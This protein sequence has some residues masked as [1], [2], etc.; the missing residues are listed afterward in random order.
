MATG[1]CYVPFACVCIDDDSHALHANSRSHIDCNRKLRRVPLAKKSL[2]PLASFAI[3]SLDRLHLRT[4]SSCLFFSQTLVSPNPNLSL[5]TSDHHFSLSKPSIIFPRCATSSESW[6]SSGLFS[7]VEMVGGGGSRRTDGPIGISSTNVFAALDSLRRKKKSDGSSKSKG[8][9]KKEPEP[10]P[11]FWAPTP[12]TVKSWADVDD[13]DDYYA[14]TAPPRSVW[15]APEPAQEQSKESEAVGE[16]ILVMLWL[17]GLCIL[18]R[19]NCSFRTMDRASVAALEL[20]MML[21]LLS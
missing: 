7:E 3:K 16:G 14:T 18:G 12:L 6:N 9:S 17:I 13:D 1:K 19:S 8:S 4:S 10:E 15:G 5:D 21:M 11:V 2:F 20:R